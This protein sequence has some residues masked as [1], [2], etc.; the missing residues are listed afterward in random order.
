MEEGHKGGVI[1]VFEE[2]MKDFASED[3]CGIA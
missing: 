2:A 1:C 3:L